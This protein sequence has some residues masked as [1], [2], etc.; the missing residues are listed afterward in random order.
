MLIQNHTGR[1]GVVAAMA[2]LAV[3]VSSSAHAQVMCNQLPVLFLVQDMSGS[4]D[5]APN[6]GTTTTKWQSAQQVVP[7]VVNQFANRFRFGVSMFPGA[8]NGCAAGGVD[9]SIGASPSQVQSLY[10]SLA[11]GGGTPTA[12]SL[13]SAKNYLLS[14]GLSSPAY[15]LLITDGLPNCNAS[16]NVATCTS[17]DPAATTAQ[18]KCLD[19]TQTVAA[20]Q[21]LRAANIPVYVVGFG[22]GITS[23]GNQAVLNAIA[24]AG[25]TSTA[26]IATNQAQL[27]TALNQVASTASTCCVNACTQGSA[28]CSATGQRQTC[29]LDT[30]GVCTVWANNDCPTMTAC[31]G[32]SCVACSNQCSAGATRCGSSG[33]AEVCQVGTSGCTSWVVSRACA[34]GEV[35]TN[36]TCSGCSGCTIGTSRCTTG[37]VAERCDFNI[38]TGCS[39][40]TAQ[41]C[42]TGSVCQSGQCRACNTTCT[43]GTKRC[44][45]QTVELCTADAQGCTAWMA[46]QTCTNFCSGGA[47]GVCGTTCTV[48]AT[49]CNG[50]TAEACIRDMNNCPVWQSSNPC[51]AGSF[52]ENGGCQACATNCTLGA[53]RC[54]ASGVVEECRQQG[55]T[56]CPSWTTVSACN[57]SA[58]ERCDA[59][60]GACLPPCQDQCTEGA[61]R[62]SAMTPQACE[63]ADTGC[64]VW[65]SRAACASQ[66]VCTSGACRARCTPG[67]LET[68]PQGTICSTTTEGR[69]CLPGLD[70]GGVLVGPDPVDAGAGGAGGSGAGGTGGAGAG[71]GNG[72][73]AGSGNG[74]GGSGNGSGTG[75]G[76]G[77]IESVGARSTGCGCTAAEGSLAAMALVWA[78]GRRRRSAR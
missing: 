9:L 15:V 19:D 59:A 61:G 43:A 13:T 51:A 77:I 75:G 38:F 23:T 7:Q 58:G 40:W 29:Q 62:C 68:C 24:S 64:T 12:A 35:C 56:G 54:A 46:S 18:Y 65:R 74:S 27:T 39:Q 47:C 16:L 45:G 70:D 5:E 28:R 53:K 26:Y 48:G 55:T 73:S 11:P 72:G 66:E 17:I 76:R 6:T 31:T 50:N 33:N 49:Q 57:I 71:A 30:A 21:A 4:M 22:S 63:R 69:L 3:F 14:Q 41:S 42:T 52:C 32:G 34:Y 1:V 78:L 36:G 44:N 8:N 37:T 67:E 60:T 10:S 2:T 20:A 25:G